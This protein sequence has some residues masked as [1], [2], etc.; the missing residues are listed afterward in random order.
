MY[1]K[2]AFLIAIVALV[3]CARTVSTGTRYRVT[4]LQNAVFQ[5][6]ELKA[7]DYR[8]SLADS[9]VTIT[10]ENGKHPLEVPVKVE[11]EDK[12]FES[13]TVRLSTVNG[14]AVVAEI[15][16]GG[17]KTRLVFADQALLP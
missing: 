14:K 17:T 12:K 16:L 9:K 2:L 11:T 15:R 7:G 10:S 4:L 8:L 5:G 13:T 6:N 1:K 3:A